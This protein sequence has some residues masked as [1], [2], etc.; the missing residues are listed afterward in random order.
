MLINAVL[1]IPVA[2]LELIKY[3]LV[4]LFSP[5][6]LNVKQLSFLFNVSDVGTG[7]QSVHTSSFE[8]YY[9]P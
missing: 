1:L 3:P 7:S 8:P 5:L 4:R 9:Y 2:L 6:G